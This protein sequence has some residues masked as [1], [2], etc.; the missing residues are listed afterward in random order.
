MTAIDYDSPETVDHARRAT[1]LVGVTVQAKVH[2][3]W[4]AA[5]QV[6]VGPVVDWEY[7]ASG[8]AVLI[9]VGD[10]DLVSCYVWDCVEIA[11]LDEMRMRAVEQVQEALTWPTP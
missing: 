6:V 1:A 7:A 9:A 5:D 4:T 3:P 10:G 8:P 11:G 2:G